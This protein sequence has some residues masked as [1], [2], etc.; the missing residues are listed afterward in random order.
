MKKYFVNHDVN[1]QAEFT[2]AQ[3]VERFL[4]SLA[5]LSGVSVKR[6]AAVSLPSLAMAA[7]L[8]W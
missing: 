7:V 4:K 6:D 2:N 8:S 5:D 3:K 1:R